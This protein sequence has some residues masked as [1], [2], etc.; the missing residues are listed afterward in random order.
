MMTS[1]M[2]NPN[3]RQELQK[4]AKIRRISFHTERLCFL[5]IATQNFTRLSNV[6]I[7]F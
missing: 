4:L 5:S 3:K 1:L 6:L 7:Q 2:N